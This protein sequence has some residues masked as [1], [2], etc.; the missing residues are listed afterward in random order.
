MDVRKIKYKL[1][2]KLKETDYYIRDV[3]GEEY[4]FSCPY[5]ND[6]KKFYIKINPE[7]NYRIVCH[8]FK[9]DA[10]DKGLFNEETLGLFGINDKELLEGILYINNNSDKV[11]TKNFNTAYEK[12]KSHRISFS[13]DIPDIKLSEKT[14]YI[15]NRIGK[16]LTKEDFINMKAVTSIEDFLDINNIEERF[17]S[18]K[19]MYI[20]ERDFVGFLSMGNSHILL[21]NTKNNSNIRWIKYPITKESKDN[22]IFYVMSSS[23]DVFTKERII[24]NISEGIFDILSIYY[25]IDSDHSNSLYFVVTGHYYDQLLLYLLDL[26]FVGSNI[27]INIYADNDE[28]YNK[29]AKQKT[30][31]SYFK[32]KLDLYKHLYKEINIIYNLMGKD[33]GVP[34]DM[35]SMKKYK[36]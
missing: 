29:D 7:D 9:C 31:L 21:R 5:C 22:K 18:D 11:D 28:Q 17:Y 25:N 30:T 16:K 33:F 13:Y 36:L 1:I 2:Q 8:C 35:I 14:E 34:R 24:I 19:L 15:E 12:G 26:G 20:L 6:S 4:L 3:D 32:K 10:P 23:V 27:I